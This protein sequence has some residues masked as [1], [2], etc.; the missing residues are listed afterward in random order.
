MNLIIAPLAVEMLAAVVTLMLYNHPAPQKYISQFLNIV[1]FIFSVMLVVTVFKEGT[2][3]INLGSWEIPYGITFVADPFAAIMVGMTGFVTLAAIPYVFGGIKI[4]GD[5]RF[6]CPLIH[7]LTAGTFMAFLTGDFFNLF[8]AFELLLLSS[9]VLISL[10][11]RKAQIEA[12]LKYVMINMLGSAFF[13]SSIGLLYANV[14]ALNMAEVGHRLATTPELQNAAMLSGTLMLI[15]FCL[16]AAVFPFGFWKPAIYPQAHPLIIGIFAA[17]LSKV[18]MY[19]VLRL[20]SIILIYDYNF[21]KHLLLVIAG[22]TMV[23][24][25]FGAAI[26]YNIR[27]ILSFHSVSQMGYIMVALALFTPFSIAA[28]VFYFLHHSFTKANLFFCAGLLHLRFGHDDLKKMGGVYK[29]NLMTSGLFMIS[30]L[31]L[32]GI[33]PLAGFFGKWFVLKAAYIHGEWVL[34]F[35][36]MFVGILTLFSMIKIWNEAFW[37]DS[38]ENIP[39]PKNR[40]PIGPLISTLMMT[41]SVIAVGVFAQPLFELSYEAGLVI[42]EPDKYI[43]AVLGL[44]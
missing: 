33:P 11:R 42:V 29:T 37:K 3:V 9:F 1:A 34:L 26:Q 8:V 10:G 39:E 20:F 6:Y 13:L 25:V 22:F 15:A 41:L 14:G 24:G 43:N 16:K 36:G 28:A 23:S 18:A 12:A 30:A 44:E 27:R 32:A 19:A 17:L 40:I 38:P 31:S 21:F 5:F 2:Q 7:F 4:E 35:T